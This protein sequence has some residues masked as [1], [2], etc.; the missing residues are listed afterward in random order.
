MKCIAG[1]G[2]E[3]L[4]NCNWGYA[5]CNGFV[6]LAEGLDMFRLGAIVTDRKVN[7]SGNFPF[8]KKP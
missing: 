4:K 5:Y 7:L 3:S 6:F 1:I 2:R 8:M